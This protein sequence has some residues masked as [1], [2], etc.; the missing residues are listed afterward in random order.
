MISK[1]TQSVG[2]EFEK[3]PTRPPLHCTALVNVSSLL[4]SVNM[5]PTTDLP[6]LAALHPVVCAGGDGL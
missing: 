4:W 6:A 2:G 5:P 3:R 1:G